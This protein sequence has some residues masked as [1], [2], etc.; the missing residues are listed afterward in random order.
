[1]LALPLEE[2]RAQLEAAGYE[3]EVRETRS[4]G[5]GVPQGARRVVRQQHEGG[6][7]WLVVTPERYERPAPASAAVP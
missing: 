5:R 4:P 3:V 6:R 7:V 1:V 2:A